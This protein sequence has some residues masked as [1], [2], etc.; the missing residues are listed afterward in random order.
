LN[1]G[2]YV[3]NIADTNADYIR[4]DEAISILG[5]T[6]DEFHGLVWDRKISIA[7]V[8]GR[9]RFLREV[10]EGYKNKGGLSINSPD[11]VKA[12]GVCSLDEAGEEEKF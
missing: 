4:V 3:E 12:E 11:T 7:K 1:Y 10:I 8:N 5:I 6:K 2:G 9:V